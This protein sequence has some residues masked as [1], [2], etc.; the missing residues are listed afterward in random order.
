MCRIR[1]N[2][3]ADIAALLGPGGVVF[4]ST[5]DVGSLTARAFGRRWHFYYPYHL[6]YFAPRTLARAAGPH[7]LRVL[8][9]RHRG[10]VRSA[11]YMI[12]YAAEFI[13]GAAAPAWARWFDGRYV[14]INLFDTMY[15]ALGRSP[16]STSPH[17][18]PLL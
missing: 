13:A 14:P 15:V 8:D 12:R 9:C 6:S 5:P 16:A 11:G 7:G 2:F 4:V 10:R 1:S 3:F 17:R 18:G